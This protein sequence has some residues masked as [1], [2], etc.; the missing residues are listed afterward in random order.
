MSDPIPASSGTV[1]ADGAPP[2]RESDARKLRLAT[3]NV[4]WFTHLFD[5]HDRLK[6]DDKWSARYNVTRAQQADAVAAVLSAVDADLFLITEAPNDGVKSKRSTVQALEHFASVYRLRQRKALIGFPSPTYQEIALLYD[7]ERLE[8]RHDPIGEPLT[9][10]AAAEVEPFHRS[11]EHAWG[12]VFPGAPRFDGVFPWDVDGAGG[13]PGERE[14]NLFSKPPLEAAVRDRVFGW[15]FR[16]IGAHLKSK[17]PRFNG[18]EKTISAEELESAALDT[19]RKHLGQSVWLRARVAEHLAA[20]ENLVVLGDFN[21]GP[22]L[23]AYE[24]ELGH[25][26]LDLIYGAEAPPEDQL[27]MPGER[28]HPTTRFWRRDIEAYDEAAIDFVLLSRE[29]AARCDPAWT[30]WHPDAE[31]RVAGNPALRQAIETA[32]DHYPVSVDLDASALSQKTPEPPAER[33]TGG[34]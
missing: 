19:R 11:D 12:Q 27:A 13:E 9:A 29:L 24:A 33:S 32:S 25:S 4:E 26:G 8:A 21:D 1:S 14:L 15:D 34:P 6:Y 3:Y 5:R 2:K 20:G 7:P 23:D 30:V 28:M 22:G 18:P 16:L 31:P 17:N 10:E